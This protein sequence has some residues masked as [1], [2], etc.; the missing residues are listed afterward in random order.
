MNE[1]VGILYPMSLLEVGIG[2]DL[3]EPDLTHEFPD[4]VF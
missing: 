4:I 3:L 2:F 1:K